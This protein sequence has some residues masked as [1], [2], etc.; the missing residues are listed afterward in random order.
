MGNFSKV[1]GS[2][3]GGLVGFGGSRWGLPTEWATPEVVGGLTAV[4]SGLFTFFF[5]ANTS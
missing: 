2:V 5:P 4:A 1:I 3:I